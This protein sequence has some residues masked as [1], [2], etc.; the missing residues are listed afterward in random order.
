MRFSA[1]SSPGISVCSAAVALAFA[2]AFAPVA[3]A[4]VSLAPTVVRSGSEVDLVF[5][6]P[7]ESARAGVVRVTI[8]A[9]RDFL[10]DDAEAKPG[11][12]QARVG[13]TVTWSGARP[14]PKGEFARFA[15]RGTVPRRRET[16]LFNVL[17]GAAGGKT[18]T[19]RVA[20]GVRNGENRDL[21]ARTLGKLALGT[22]IGAALLALAGGFL[23]LYV[24]LRPPPP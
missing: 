12:R 23:S 1:W 9:P 14:I 7:N 18:T 24:W 4:H 13:Q 19:Y 11:W 21:G 10:I 15:I 22:G 16:I 20:L 17:V 2:L 8:G 5:A 3:A 6:V